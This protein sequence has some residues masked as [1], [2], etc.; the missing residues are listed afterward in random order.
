[1]SLYEDPLGPQKSEGALFF[2]GVQEKYF[3]LTKHK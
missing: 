1:M 3:M 2:E